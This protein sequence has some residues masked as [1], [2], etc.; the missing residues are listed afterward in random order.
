MDGDYWTPYLQRAQQLVAEERATVD[1]EREAFEAFRHRVAKHTPPTQGGGTPG[2]VVTRSFARDDAILDDY[3]STVMALSHYESDY[4]EEALE[5]MEIEFGPEIADL[6]GRRAP[7]AYRAV[8]GAASAAVAKRELFLEELGAERDSLEKMNQE[9]VDIHRAVDRLAD[10]ATS[11]EVDEWY[12]ALDRLDELEDR[13]GRLLADR[14]QQLRDHDRVLSHGTD[15]TPPLVDYLYADL[16]VRYPALY[17][18][19][20]LL[21][22]IEDV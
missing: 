20:T 17:S 19:A 11:G 12:D 21:N 5:N 2:G 3:E 9:V 13:S 15:E 6:V 4:G 8:V 7:S 18:L 10:E 22:R 14:Q 1:A 16:P